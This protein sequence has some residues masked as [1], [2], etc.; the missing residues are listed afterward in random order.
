M[1]A[2]VIVAV[3]L[4]I[5]ATGTLMVSGLFWINSPS[6][7]VAAAAGPIVTMLVLAAGLLIRSKALGG[8]SVARVWECPHCGYDLRGAGRGGG[9]VRVCPECGLPPARAL[10]VTPMSSSA[11][12]RYCGWVNPWNAGRC[13]KCRVKRWR[14][15]PPVEPVRGG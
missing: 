9:S 10:P 7:T 5:V 15:A 2:F 8:S 3:L 14:A 12:C 6:W 4:G 13:R 11:P 1:I